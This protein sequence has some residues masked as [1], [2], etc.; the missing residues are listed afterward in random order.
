MVGWHKENKLRLVQ[1]L[2]F[3]PEFCIP[4]CD[5]SHDTS[6]VGSLLLPLAWGEAVECSD[7]HFIQIS[8]YKH[9]LAFA[10][11]RVDLYDLLYYLLYDLLYYLLYDLLYDLLYVYV[12]IF[13]QAICKELYVRSSNRLAWLPISLFGVSSFQ[14]CLSSA[15]ERWMYR[16]VLYHCFILILVEEYSLSSTIVK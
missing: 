7:W 13:S 8:R 5:I 2:G 11:K 15:I 3:S 16:V 14:R 6:H 12:Y 10:I 9:G 1:C 4:M